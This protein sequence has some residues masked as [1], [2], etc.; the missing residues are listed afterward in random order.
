MYDSV[1]DGPHSF[2]A[3]YGEHREALE[4][5]FEEY[6]ELR[7]HARS[8]GVDFMAT[9]FDPASAEFLANVGVEAIKIASADLTNVPL[10]RHAAR[11]GL[12]LVISTGGAN[13]ADVRRAH[14]IVAPHEAGLA[15]LQCTAI[16]PALPEHL[17]LRVIS[18]YREEFPD[19]I[20]GFSGHD[21]GADGA[22]TAYTLGARIIEK[23]FTLD[24]NA[25][26]SDHHFSMEPNEYRDMVERILRTGQML[27]SPNKTIKDS[28]RPAMRKMAKHLVAARDLGVGEIIVAGDVLIR[29]AGSGMPPYLEEELL[30]CRLAR[31]VRRDDPFPDLSENGAYFE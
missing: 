1:Y 7:D 29:T 26:G 15:L 12:P 4:F 20:V 23:H 22:L 14:D 21:L 6:I 3:T 16:Y 28:E 11:T 17:D 27:G 24:R 9:A 25:K 13:M 8:R 2:G 5:G 10:L 19:V 31:E 18:T 30:G